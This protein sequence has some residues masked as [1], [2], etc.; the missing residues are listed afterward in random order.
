MRAK[1]LAKRRE[2]DGTE[3]R[4]GCRAPGTMETLVGEPM[5]TAWKWFEPVKVKLM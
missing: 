4:S 2:F 1:R 5:V 3:Y